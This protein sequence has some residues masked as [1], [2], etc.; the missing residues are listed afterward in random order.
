M[1]PNLVPAGKGDWTKHKI[2]VQRTSIMKDASVEALGITSTATGGRADIL[3]ADDVVDRRNALNFPALRESIK[4]SWKSD[5]T[6]LLEPEGRIWYICTL[7]HTADLSHELQRS[8]EYFKVEHKIGPNLEPIWPEKWGAKEL[9]ARKRE[10][11]STEFDR[12]FR[13]IALSGDIVVVQPEWISFYAERPDDLIIYTGYDLAIKKKATND[14]FASVAAGF[15]PKTGL[16]YILRAWRDRLSFPQQVI[17]L[18]REGRHLKPIAMG[19]EDVA[20]QDALREHLVDTTLLPVIPVKHRGLSKTLRLEKITPYL[21]NGK[22]LFAAHLNPQSPY[23]KEHRGDLVTELLQSP[24]S[25]HDDLQD[26]FVHVVMLI[27]EDFIANLESEDD[28]GSEL[29]THVTIAG[30]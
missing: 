16:I 2:V 9:L 12:G 14:Y 17:T 23:F 5:W 21:E 11:G 22:I 30:A 8:P 13:N 3:I 1:F 26:A 15:S 19:V 6:N 29:Q 10:I 18:K 25:A 27:V 20:Y 7:W 28:I 24:L 4:G